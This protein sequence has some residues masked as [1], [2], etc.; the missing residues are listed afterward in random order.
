MKPLSG[1]QLTCP[2][3]LAKPG[4]ELF[5]IADHNGSVQFLQSTI[6]ID[7][8]FINEALKGRKPEE[9][10]RFAGKCIERGCIHWASDTKECTLV[11][12]LIDALGN[13]P[14]A[15]SLTMCPIRS[16]CRWFD[17][18]GELACVNCTLV[19]RDDLT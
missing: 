14:S 2:S 6:V 7:N 11:G 4:A 13:T 9:R 18:A 19:L 5:G 3:Y 8:T 17:Q 1:K 10:F 16:R 12:K 15:P